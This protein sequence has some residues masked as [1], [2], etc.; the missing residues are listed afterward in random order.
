MTI[1]ERDLDRAEAMPIEALQAWIPS[2]V[3]LLEAPD[4]RLRLKAVRALARVVSD[5]RAADAMVRALADPFS[6]VRW[7]A[8]KGARVRDPKVIGALA[9]A[10][11]D[12]D[13][14]VRVFAAES[15]GQIGGAH[16][17]E[18]LAAALRHPDADTRR[19]AARAL[20]WT[21]TPA[22]AEPLLAALG[23]P[24]P[25]VRAAAATALGV[26]GDRRVL[27][28]L[29][30]L[31][32]EDYAIV[33]EDQWANWT[34]TV[35]DAAASAA[36]DVRERVGIEPEDI[37]RLVEA[38]RMRDPYHDAIVVG[39]PVQAVNVLVAL[40]ERAV[41]PLLAAL[42]DPKAGLR[43]NAALILG[44]IRDARAIE[45]LIAALADPEPVVRTQAVWA[46]RDL[47]DPR[48]A[49]PLVAALRDEADEARS[50]ARYALEKMGEAA[51]EPL[52]TAADE[53]GCRAE[54]FDVLAVVGDERALA[55][56]D[57]RDTEAAR[58]AA[59]AIRRRRGG[60][61]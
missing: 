20:G 56:L 12:P 61:A 52:L 31:A 54:V 49:P 45:P 25:P 8:A 7:E 58:Q 43:A 3:G 41:E 11:D 48:A 53:P 6:L 16:A 19:A 28:A 4:Q 36:G 17:V 1:D 42:R 40:G 35:S 21:R 34:V 24:A 39:R 44:R 33:E 46:L 37:A 38:L 13:S 22:A 26:V 27:P 10:L 9:R 32:F 18:P 14:G 5:P 15:L 23:D 60:G 2:L 29:E 55:R 57:A 51:I 50:A 47:G 30:R 59:G